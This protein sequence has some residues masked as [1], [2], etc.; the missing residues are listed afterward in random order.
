MNMKEL[1]ENL[2]PALKNLNWKFMTLSEYRQAI[3]RGELLKKE[4]LTD[5]ILFERMYRDHPLAFSNKLKHSG[6]IRIKYPPNAGG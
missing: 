2:Q 6:K 5:D 1:S 4:H 3:A